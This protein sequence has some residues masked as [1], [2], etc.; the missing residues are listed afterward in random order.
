MPYFVTTAPNG[1]VMGLFT[2]EP[3]YVSPPPEAQQIPDEIADILKK[4]ISGKG[5]ADGAVFDLPPD[6]W[7][8]KYKQ[9]AIIE[10]A[11][12]DANVAPI[13]YMGT[14]FQADAN[15]QALIAAVLTAS[16]GALPADFAWF[17][18]NNQPVPMSFAQLQG[19]AGAILLRGQPLFVKKQMLKAAIRDAADI[20][21]VEAI[22][23]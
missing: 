15:S 19:L 12:A 6:V 5:Y 3:G 17:D 16:G 22:V 13:G 11:Y 23:W 7:S 18:S 14:T 21:T 9:L 1:A 2:D 4:G 20:P 8:H 10:D